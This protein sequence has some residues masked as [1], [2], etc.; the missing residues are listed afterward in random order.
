MGMQ[1]YMADRREEEIQ[2]MMAE[3]GLG[4][5][6]CVILEQAEQRLSSGL[7]FLEVQRRERANGGCGPEKGTSA[8]GS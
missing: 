4:H 2:Q 6:A 5:E 1:K 3:T 8:D 7:W